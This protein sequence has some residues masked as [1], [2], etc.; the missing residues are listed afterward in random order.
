[1]TA[2]E[3]AL[4]P[5]GFL[6][7]VSPRSG[8][9]F[10]GR[11][12]MRRQAEN[13]AAISFSRRPDSDAGHLLLRVGVSL[14]VDAIARFEGGCLRPF[15]RSPGSAPTQAMEFEVGAPLEAFTPGEGPRPPRSLL[16]E[17]TPSQSREMRFERD[18]LWARGDLD[19]M[20]GL[21]RS[22]VV[23][24]V[25]PVLDACTTDRRLCEFIL[26]GGRFG[27]L[28]LGAYNMA[29]LTR[30]FGPENKFQKYAASVETLIARR[31]PSLRI[32]LVELER[33]RRGE[34]LREPSS[35]RT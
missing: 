6:Q 1:M 17:A 30:A 9:R 15:S 34:V 21:V 7:R 10:S 5:L 35:V 8:D 22:Q 31:E 29:V 26:A 3:K 20:V 16:V 14:T 2:A 27:S 12:L 11:L 23:E 24:Q 32:G 19:E 33:L 4:A 28:A 18:T 25:L 13:W